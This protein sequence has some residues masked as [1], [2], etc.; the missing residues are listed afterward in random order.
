MKQA[1]L[2]SYAGKFFRLSLRR[3]NFPA[4]R[5][6][7]LLLIAFPCLVFAQKNSPAPST[8]HHP[9]STVADKFSRYQ[10]YTMEQG[11]SSNWVTDI[12]QDDDGFL[13]FSTNEG[14][15]RFDG[16]RFTSF[17]STADQKG[18]PVDGIT[19]LLALSGHRLLVGTDKG[20]C[21]LHTRR[22]EFEPVALPEQTAPRIWKLYRARNGQI[23]VG[24]NTGAF[25]LNDQLE[26]VQSY[27]K[28]L[29]PEE[30]PGPNFVLDFLELPDGTVAVKF[31]L[32]PP[33]RY[34]PWQV[35]DF[36]QKKMEPLAQRLPRCGVLDTALAPNATVTDDLNGIW[37][38][39]LGSYS[40][41][42][43]YRFDWAS[44][45]SQPLLK[46]TY[47]PATQE[48]RQ[49]QYSS[50][51]LLPDSLLFLQRFFGPPLIYD[52]RD[53]STTDLPQWKTSLPDGKSIATFL[54]RD[55]NLWLCPRF[56][57]IYF[58][59]LKNLPATPMTALNEAHKKRMAAMGVSEEW[60]GFLCAEHMGRWAVSS[61]NGGLYSM[62]K[63]GLGVSGPVLGNPFQG[64]A[65]VNDFAPDRG[66]ILWTSALGGM[67]WYDPVN[68]T[69][70]LLKERIRGLDSLDGRFLV[71]DHYGLIWGRV[72]GNGVCCFDTRSRRLTHF[73][74]RGENAPFP[75]ASATACTE[76]PDGDMWFSFG[77]EEKYLVRWRRA[78]G[79]FEK[80][81]PLCPPGIAGS[82][83]YNLLADPHDNLWL[84]VGQRWFVMDIRT[85]Q[86]LPFG[87]DNGLITNSPEGICFDRDGNAWVATSYGLSRYDPRSRQLRSFYQTD[88]LLSNI[89]ANVEL[90][91]TA[92]NILFVSTDR[93][94]CLF[95]PDKIGAAAPAPPTFIT[96]LRVSDQPI[97]LPPSGTLPL[98][99]SQNDLR[100]EFTGINFINGPSNR[101]QYS[102]ELEDSPVEWKDAGTDNFANF[103][104]L[105]PG[106]YA[107]RARTANSD[108]VWGTEEAMLRIAIY[109]PW[110]QT[111]TFQFALLGLLGL[112]AWW[113]YRLQISAVEDREKEKARVR[114]QLADLEM[115]AL[116]SQ[117]NPHFVFN[118]LNSVQNFIL[119]NDPREASR[120]LT[121]FARLMRLILEN[122]ES[123]M[124][125]LAREIELLRYYTE[126]EQLRFN[127]RFSFD[128][129]IDNSLNSES[130]SIPG[131]LIQP[132]IENAI[133][134]G[135][136]HKTEP[137]RLS[138]RFFKT[139]ENTLLCEVEDDGVGRARATEMEKD[140]PK[141]HRSTGLANIR[142]RLEVLN[143]QL[144]DDIRLEFQDLYDEAGTARGTCVRVRMPV[145]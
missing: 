6:S 106:R 72:R 113:L 100:I 118:A 24:T 97:S 93:G 110:W 90:I 51:F 46:N 35:I 120:Y 10:H 107:F 63:A 60:F 5:I 13:W 134:H 31:T 22:L 104:N 47:I 140:R 143:A 92:R 129:Q 3:K 145:V 16:E 7:L 15:N 37:Y 53:G 86:V 77:G 112:L 130:V 45:K 8:V 36:Q 116:R 70:G 17:F 49:G 58:L 115:K 103:L 74:S 91:D 69:H 95:E 21:L 79:V 82:K 23:W 11:L 138:V 133:W 80:V 122:S 73:P 50:P 105:P 89:I 75:I 66:D 117:M 137:G 61:G 128:F 67:G 131:M 136:M 94:M 33:A 2:L 44:L 14:L 20:L 34:S 85:R 78:T 68:N 57:G 144:T 111:W 52:L 12:A 38:T 109:P 114:Q 32:A 71:R 30:A 1:A 81:E 119:K 125:P 135:L 126:L 48:P 54:D 41:S 40:L 88:G 121:K 9:P 55:G 28:P 84:Y 4:Y 76:G 42:S 56:E 141:N 59:T 19:K 101:Y 26:A 25:V 87:K 139:G 83:A 98:L 124:V 62:D 18:L 132:H 96:S 39:A 65:Y 43:L 27:F 99:Y 142:H 64:Y 29:Q 127:H 108:G 102:M 123:P